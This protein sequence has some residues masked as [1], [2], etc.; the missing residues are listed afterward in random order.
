ML[1]YYIYRNALT[2][3][4]RIMISVLLW[5]IDCS[6]VVTNLKAHIG[7]LWRAIFLLLHY[8]A[9]CVLVRSSVQK[10][11]TPLYQILFRF[12]DAPQAPKG[13]HQEDQKWLERALVVLRAEAA[14]THTCM[15]ASAPWLEP[16]TSSEGKRLLAPFSSCPDRRQNAR[17]VALES[18]R[19]WRIRNELMSFIIPLII[20]L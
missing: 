10:V 7:H 5:L 9:F 19:Q 20:S 13:S 4:D 12:W 6:V 18:G 3:Y 16:T 2:F 1:I 15:R 8:Y 17:G 14:M 11:W